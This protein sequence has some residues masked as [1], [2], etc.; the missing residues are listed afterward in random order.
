[1]ITLKPTLL[2]HLNLRFLETP[3]IFDT[4]ENEIYD[5]DEEALDVAQLMDG[6]HDLEE[7]IIKSRIAS[8]SNINNFIAYLIQNGLAYDN[9]SGSFQR[10]FNIRKS[11]DPSLRQ[12]LIHITTACNLRCVHCYID[13]EKTIHMKKELFSKILQEYDDMQGLRV[14]ITGGE[15]LLHPNFRDFIEELNKFTFRKTLFTNAILLDENT[16]K[17][18]DDKIDEIQIS[19]DGTQSHDIFRKEEGLY[20]EIIEKLKMLKNLGNFTISVSTMIHQKNLSEMEEL[21]NVMRD[22]KI[23]NWYLD[24]PVIAGEYKKNPTY[25]AEITDAAEVLNN[26]GWGEQ[27]YD[28]VD[29]YACGYHLCAIMPNADICKCGLFA[30]EPVGNYEKDSLL[31]CWEIISQKYNW[32]QEDLQCKT[33]NCPNIE[34]CR[35]GCRFRAKELTND[36]HGIDEVKCKAFKFDFNKRA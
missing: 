35:G 1:M 21:Q 30:E 4:K 18:L 2:K 34:D 17:F 7:D 5:L 9:K 6:K 15:P 24:I 25:H 29:D 20:D 36:I 13:R 23:D 19:I 27:I 26:Y 33:L 10:T 11:P 14:M 16:I 12:L 31:D 28:W 3:V 32:K 8:E 22:L